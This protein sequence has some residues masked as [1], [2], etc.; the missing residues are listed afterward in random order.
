MNGSADDVLRDYEESVWPPYLACEGVARMLA[1]AGL[2][3]KWNEELSGIPLVG[4]ATDSM[5]MAALSIANEHHSSIVE[6]MKIG[7]AGSAAALTRPAFEAFVR[8]IWLL[9]VKDRGSLKRYEDGKDTDDP[10]RLIRRCMKETKFA[11]YRDLL[12]S[13]L[14]SKPALHG[15]VH[16][17][18]QAVLRRSGHYEPDSEELVSLLRFSTGVSLNATLELLDLFRKLVPAAQREEVLVRLGSLEHSARFFQNRLALSEKH[19][20]AG[21]GIEAV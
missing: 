7:H 16:N 11:P 14:Q 3:A 8:G 2:V 17:S 1:F 18:Y 5:A 4:D 9:H 15:F 19:G 20:T 6:L 13:W 12:D 10:E 21:L